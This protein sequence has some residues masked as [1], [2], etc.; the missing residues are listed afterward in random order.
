MS[1]VVRPRMPKTGSRNNRWPFGRRIG[2][3]ARPEVMAEIA[4]VTRGQVIGKLGNSGNSSEAH[5]HLPSNERF[6][7]QFVKDQPWGAYNW[8]QG[9]NHSL[10]ALAVAWLVAA[11]GRTV[12]YLGAGVAA[13]DLERGRA[14]YDDRRWAGLAEDRQALPGRDRQPR[15]RPH[16]P[17]RQRA[18][19]GR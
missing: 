13:T 14:A 16:D 8:Y 10:G 18:R 2:R 3:A 17:A 15:R 19:A 9:D 4:R 7:L 5:L 12:D 11:S 6:E 1:F